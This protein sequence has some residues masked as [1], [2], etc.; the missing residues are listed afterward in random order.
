V[1]LHDKHVRKGLNYGHT[2]GHAIEV[3]SNY[4]MPHGLAV[5]HGMLLMNKIFGYTHSVFEHH[6]LELIQGTPISELDCQAVI[7]QD[8]K[9]NTDGTITCIVPSD[10]G[11]KFI[12]SSSQKIQ[13]QLELIDHL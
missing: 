5:V 10:N 12:T 8:K 6:C 9:M 7:E 2:L 4:T 13:D 3:V 1:D 11:L